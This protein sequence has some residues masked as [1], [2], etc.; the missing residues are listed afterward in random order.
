M[1]KKNVL[2][3]DKSEEIKWRYLG[4]APAY[5]EKIKKFE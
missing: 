4:R 3:Y 1:E 2:I 5:I